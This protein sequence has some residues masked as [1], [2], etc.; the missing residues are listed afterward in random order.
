[1]K[2]QSRLGVASL[3][4]GFGYQPRPQIERIVPPSGTQDQETRVQVFGTNFTTKTIIY[5]GQTLA[6]ATSLA[7][8]SWQGATEIDGVVPGSRGQTTVWAFDAGNGW[9]RLLDGFSWIAP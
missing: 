5:L 7:A 6:D 8:Q 4:S 3:E 9:T 2:V 1:V